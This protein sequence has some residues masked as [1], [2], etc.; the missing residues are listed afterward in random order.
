[1]KIHTESQLKAMELILQSKGYFEE[2][3]PKDWEE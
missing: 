2:Y 3:N 1:M